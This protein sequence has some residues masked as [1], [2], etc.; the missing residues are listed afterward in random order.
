MIVLQKKSVNNFIMKFKVFEA[1]AGIGSQRKAL[2]TLSELI[3]N[4]DFE[5]VAT[6]EWDC[7]ANISYNAMKNKKDKSKKSLEEK[8]DYL[9]N[10]IH[11]LDSKESID[12]Q[13]IVKKGDRFVSLLYESYVSNNNLGNITKITGRNLIGIAENIDVITYSFPCQD[14][15]SA[16]SLHHPSQGMTKGSGSR[17]SLLWEVERILIELNALDIKPK[18]LILENVTNILSPEH[19]ENYKKWL[20][21]LKKINYCTQTYILSSEDFGIPQKR[22]R[23][24]ALSV[25]EGSKINFIDTFKER[26]KSNLELREKIISEAKALKEEYDRLTYFPKKDLNKILKTNYKNSKYNHEAIDSIPRRTSSR[27][28]MYENNP[29]LFSECKTERDIY[30]H[31]NKKSQF[32]ENCAILSATLTTKQD[33]HPNAGI[34]SVLDKNGRPNIS[35]KNIN[36][37]YKMHYRFL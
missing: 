28:K 6:S 35:L 29:L 20:E 25:Y 11:S 30:K 4:F 10:F 23:V 37:I 16:S 14:L 24:I 22:K 15:S 9:S 1:F 31:K 18:F 21:E 27:I 33:R 17:S 5:I 26:E 3:E 8:I 7:F 13:K 19:I 32:K 36:W 34:I 12:I 2:E